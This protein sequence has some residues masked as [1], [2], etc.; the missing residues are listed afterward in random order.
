MNKKPSRRAEAVVAKMLEVIGALGARKEYI[1][2]PIG[3]E[4]SLDKLPGLI[5]TIQQDTYSRYLAG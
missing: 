5:P 1:E 2:N 4:R 3:A